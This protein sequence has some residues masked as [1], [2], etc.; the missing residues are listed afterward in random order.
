MQAKTK[1]GFCFSIPY[2]FNGYKF[3]RFLGSGITSLV[4]IVEDLHSGNF[5]SAKIIPKKYIQST[6]LLNQ[7]N[8]EISIMKNANHPNIVKFHDSFEYVNEINEK[9]IVIIMEYCENGNLYNFLI[10]YGF[11]N[12]NQKKT[13]IKGFLEAI[14]YLHDKGITH[15]DIKPENIL[16][17]SN[18][19]AKLTDFGF[20]KT[21]IISGNESK[22]GTLYYAAPELFIKGQYNSIKT[23]IWSIGILIYCLSE[24]KLPFLKGNNDFIKKQITEG[25]LYFDP[26]IN[27]AL[28]KVVNRCT[29]LN[30]N[31][32]PSIH[33]LIK[34][35]YFCDNDKTND[36][37]IQDNIDLFSNED[38]QPSYIYGIRS[39]C[40]HQ[41]L[42]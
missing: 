36:Y 27:D 40:N 14:K 3:I 42:V 37:L 17:D 8:N 9:F 39:N 19:N 32:R 20:S 21:E 15:G 4:C 38:F 30:A 26:K 33:E 41:I 18:F 2:L 23:D 24:K 1:D 25:Q 7:I 13:I 6:N 16:L 22:S 34:D 5:F 31:K 29:Q 10:K 12:E 28:K 35:D 11:Q